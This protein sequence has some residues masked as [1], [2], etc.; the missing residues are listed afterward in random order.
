MVDPI[1]GAFAFSTIVG[2][3]CN[4]KSER[5]ETG[6]NEFMRWLEE[7]H[8]EGVA[9]SI[10][11]NEA[12]ELNLGAL[13]NVKHEELV[14]RLQRL[15]LLIS[16]VSGKLDAFSG[17]AQAI[18]RESVLS[19]QAVS[20]LTQLVQSEAEFFF[21]SEE[22]SPNPIYYMDRANI[23]ISYTEPR[24]IVDDLDTL[25]S[26]NLLK[27]KKNGTKKYYVTRAAVAFISELKQSA[28]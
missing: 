5:S 19:D 18:H 12:L 15:D 17:I 23:K 16:S 14:D 7:K 25:V 6:L 10:R 11:G 8:H 22:I 1:T 27:L 2:L 3:L 20:I 9:A 13:L 21:E 4:F 26:S 28:Q 24:F